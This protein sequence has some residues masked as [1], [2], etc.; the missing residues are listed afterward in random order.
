MVLGIFWNSIND[1]S[2]IT[3]K[4]DVFGWGN[5]EYGQM[6]LPD[7][8]QQVSFPRYLKALSKLGKIKSV[9]SSGSFC[10]ALTGMIF[11]Y[12]FWKYLKAVEVKSG[13]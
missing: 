7:N 12:K 5:N 3:D 10:V 4:G 6:E 11:L 13:F 8:S 9:A 2:F 1:T